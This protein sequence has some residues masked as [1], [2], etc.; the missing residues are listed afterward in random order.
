[1]AG[2]ISNIAGAPLG[3]RPT[4]VAHSSNGSGRPAAPAER[5]RAPSLP[6]TAAECQPE[7]I[8]ENASCLESMVER[9]RN[10]ALANN[11]ALSFER[12]SVDGKMYLHVIDRRTGEELYRIPRNYLSNMDP[13]LFPSHQVDVRI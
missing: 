13:N 4:P 6:G 10:A 9:A 3:A 8:P 2:E 12:D 5:E 1:M 7:G 11:T